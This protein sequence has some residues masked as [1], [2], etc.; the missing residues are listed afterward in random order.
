[1]SKIS[2]AITETLLEEIV[3]Y[4]AIELTNKQ[5]ETLKSHCDQWRDEDSIEME[6]NGYLTELGYTPNDDC[7]WVKH[8]KPINK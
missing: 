2:D 5:I 7:L 6:I 3:D 1:M 8:Y 4:G